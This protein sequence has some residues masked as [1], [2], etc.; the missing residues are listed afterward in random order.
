MITATALNL[1][2]QGKAELSRKL[3]VDLANVSEIDRGG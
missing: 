2:D 1:H 3:F